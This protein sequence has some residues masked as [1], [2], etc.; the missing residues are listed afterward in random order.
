MN[1]FKWL[2]ARLKQQWIPGAQMTNTIE[3]DDEP[4][5]TSSAED[6]LE[7]R[8]AF[9]TVIGAILDT[10]PESPAR[11]TAIGLVISCHTAVDRT[12]STP[13]INGISACWIRN[14]LH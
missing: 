9:G 13:T 8:Q 14:R 4:Q 7:L 11:Q 6:E 3:E 5:M 1:L 10:Y 2:P 12:L